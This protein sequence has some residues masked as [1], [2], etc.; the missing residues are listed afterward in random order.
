MTPVYISGLGCA[1]PAG[2]LTNRDLAAA[3]DTTEEW[4]DVHTGI[5]ERRCAPADV[6]S[7]DLGA[8]ATQTALESAGWHAADLE[9]LVCATCTPDRLVPSTASI[10]G[11]KLGVDPVCFDLNAAC[12]GFVFGLA[13]ASSM[14]VNLGLRQVAL[15]NAEKFTKVTNYQD[16]ASAIFF[17]DSAA[18]VLLQTEE[19]AAGFEIVDIVLA[20]LNEGAGYVEVPVGGYFRQEG[21]KVKEYALSGFYDSA[22]AM[23]D[24]H[25]LKAS[26]LRAFVGHQANYRLLEQVARGL[27]LSDEQHWHNVRLV[28]NQGSAGVITTFCTKVEE[29]AQTFHSGD[30]FLLTVFGAGFT[31]GSALLRWT[32]RAQGEHHVAHAAEVGGARGSL[33]LTH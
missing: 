5:L 4:I 8:A 14:A 7:S 2:R 30:L 21:R 25:H 1:I 22:G 31:H 32:H 9:M 17:G 24:R 19:P 3:V 29:Q 23:L 33:P 16:R 12:S 6:D 27:G 20:S 28:G 10:I 15:C 11:R 18:T 13:A 26:D